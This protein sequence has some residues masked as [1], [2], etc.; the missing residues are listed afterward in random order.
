[1]ALYFF[2]ACAFTRS[3]TVPARDY[4]LPDRRGGASGA[5]RR[6]DFFLRLGLALLLTLIIPHLI[7]SAIG[8]YLFYAQHNFP[9]VSFFDKDGW[10]Y[11]KAALESSS[12]MK[13]G[14]VMSWFTANIGSSS[15]PSPQLPRCLLSPAG[16]PESDPGTGQTQDHF[17]SRCRYHPLSA[18][19][20]MGCGRRSRWLA[21]QKFE[22]LFCHP[23]SR[24]NET[25]SLKP[26]CP[27]RH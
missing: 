15:H 3:S 13:T 10:A 4:G 24:P 2:M 1:M 5:G 17:A 26:K 21:C 22:G 6:A 11:E 7:G 12:F 18:L 20:S 14:P 8:S 19:E 25:Q 23:A 9:G 27:L 16:S